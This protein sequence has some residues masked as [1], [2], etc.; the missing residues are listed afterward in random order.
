MKTAERSTI[1]PLRDFWSSL[2]VHYLGKK[3]N[4]ENSITG[5]VSHQII[6]EA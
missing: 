1:R 4:T 5:A 6:K 2:L 3:Q